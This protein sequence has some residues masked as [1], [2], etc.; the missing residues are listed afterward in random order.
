M[1][2][3]NNSAYFIKK[4]EENNYSQSVIE[5]VINAIQAHAT[6]INV[7]TY[8]ALYDEQ[9][10]GY[11]NKLATDGQNICGF[12]IEDNGDG[13]TEE[14]C[15]AITEWNC[16]HKEN[17]G[18]EGVG[19]AN[20]LKTFNQTTI[21]SFV[22]NKKKSLDFTET[23][24]EKD[25]VITDITPDDVTKYELIKNEAGNYETKT[26]LTLTG[27]KN[28]IKN[29]DLAYHKD[30][31][32]E[33]IYDKVKLFLFLNNDKDITINID[34]KT[35]KTDDVKFEEPLEFTIKK[36]KET[37]S[38]TLWYSIIAS[39]KTD[40]ETHICYN[41]FSVGKMTTK[42]LSLDED[43]FKVEKHE[44]ILVLEGD[45]IKE[46]ENVKY[47]NFIAERMTNNHELRK[48][49]NGDLFNGYVSWQDVRME[50]EKQLNLLYRKVFPKRTKELYKRQSS[51]KRKYLWLSDYFTDVYTTPRQALKEFSNR[52]IEVFN[53]DNNKLKSEDINYWMNNSLTCYIKWR[54]KII[55]KL[56]SKINDKKT[57]EKEIHNLICK[58][59]KIGTDFDPLKLEENNIWL[60][61]DKFMSYN[62]VASEKTINEITNKLGNKIDKD[63]IPDIVIYKKIGNFKKAVIIEL[64]KPDS[65]LWDAGKS[66]DQC[67]FYAKQLSKSGIK[68][69]Y[70]YAIV[71]IDSD[72]RDILETRKFI[73]LF[74]TDE[75]EIWQ[76]DFGG[77][78]A[79]IQIISPTT[80]AKDAENRNQTFINIIK[81]SKGLL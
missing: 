25:I 44:I 5:A 70:C 73:K 72:A 50:V 42:P 29:R 12:K 63:K 62:Y 31:F 81:K 66:I 36:E 18:C 9:G 71:N 27:V 11:E 59:G 40:F 14:N 24:E 8:S 64:K 34:G 17:I 30:Q 23:S 69:I 21:I 48:E 33:T 67:G 10:L 75:T 76:G 49:E 56:M 16:D 52:Q 39:T 79:F 53:T 15:K 35:I 38:F 1:K 68:E 13:L 80:F 32:F 26:I 2:V 7:C 58:K 77:I 45:D 41:K 37:K 61:D 78:N 19:R 22:E 55:D 57:L 47:K 65:D 20:Y 6:N 74:S 4:F 43:K 3:A 28:N 51:N 60:I 54:Q 46:R